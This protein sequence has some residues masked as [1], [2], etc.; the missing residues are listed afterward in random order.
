MPTNDLTNLFI[1][2]SFQRLL[3]ISP[4]DG[5]TLLDGT[6]SAA[7]IN[8]S[9]SLSGSFYGIAT[10]SFSGSFAGDGFYITNIPSSSLSNVLFTNKGDQTTQTV[11]GSVK[12]TQ[13]VIAENYIISSSVSYYTQSFYS[14]STNFGDSSGDTHKFTGSI[15]M[16]EAATINGGLVSG[17]SVAPK[18]TWGGG[19]SAGSILMEPG[20]ATGND[21]IKISNVPNGTPFTGVSLS[22]LLLGHTRNIYLV[23]T[24][25]S[26]SG[27]IHLSTRDA[28]TEGDSEIYI[29][30]NA[31]AGRSTA[32]TNMHSVFIGARNSHLTSGVVNSVMIATNARSGSA[33]DTLY[34]SN[35]NASGSVRFTGSLT[36]SSSITTGEI[37]AL[38]GDLKMDMTTANDQLLITSDAGAGGE[39]YF[40]LNATQAAFELYNNALGFGY[41]SLW[42]ADDIAPQ[43]SYTNLYYAD[44]STPD[45]AFKI[46]Q[47]RNSRTANVTTGEGDENP[48]L[49]LTT[50]ALSDFNYGGGSPSAANQKIVMAWGAD[51]LRVQEGSKYTFAIGS[52]DATNAVAVNP[53][54]NYVIG[55]PNADMRHNNVV[56]LGLPNF[57][58]T[59]ADTTYVKNLYVSSSVTGNSLQVNTTNTVFQNGVSGSF[60]GSFEGN[61]HSLT[62]NDTTQQFTGSF[63]GSIQGDGS[64]LTGTGI[65]G[66]SDTVPAAVLATLTDS[67][68]FQAGNG[69]DEGIKLQDGSG[70]LAAILRETTAGGNLRL[71]AADGSTSI[72]NLNNPTQGNYLK[73]AGINRNNPAG[74][75]DPF[76]V[77]GDAADKGF[78]LYDSGSRVNAQLRPGTNGGY[79]SLF[80][81]A[82]TTAVIQLN[83]PS[84]GSYINDGNNFGI[85]TA[86]P[87]TGKLHVV[88]VSSG[89]SAR[90]QNSTVEL[91]TELGAS[92]PVQYGIST[93]SGLGMGFQHAFDNDSKDVTTANQA[94]FHFAAYR[95]T[96]FAALNN[97]N[98]LAILRGSTAH[99]VIDT[100]G[101]IMHNKWTANQGQP[102]DGYDFVGSGDPTHGFL[103]RPV[104]ITSDG[105]D[106]DSPRFRL[107]G[108]YDSDDSAGVTSSDF[109]SV[110][111]TKMLSAGSSP[112]GYLSITMPSKTDAL[113][114][115]EDGNI[116]IGTTAPSASLEVNGNVI[117]TSFTGSFSGS[118][119]GD[120]TG[121]TGISSASLS[122]V[123]FTNL[124][125]SAVQLVD[126][127]LKLSGDI[128]AENY[129]VSSSVTYMTQS[130]SSGSTIFGDSA[131]DTHQFT[132]SLYVSGSTTLGSA[133][134][135][136]HKMTGSLDVSGA[137][138][139]FSKSFLIDHPLDPNK[140]LQYG[141]L[142]GPE[143]GVYV[144]GKLEEGNIITLPDYWNALVDFDSIT[145]QLTPI[146]IYQQLFV[147]AINNENGQIE[148]EVG[149]H[150]TPYCYYFVQGTRET[151]DVEF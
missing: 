78:R 150:D 2:Q 25:G 77:Q 123:V 51:G 126:G 48:S 105:T 59:A 52:P 115:R 103:L 41:R 129:I 92:R 58:T 137:F 143:H 141:S 29:K 125:D 144:R 8:M 13:D 81:A 10:G 40:Q 148:I 11:E 6:G 74:A 79:I 73:Y 28:Y 72:A 99:W 149:G 5:I 15:Y 107:R 98:L 147:S 37:N 44:P 131:D 108:T 87:S 12:F 42:I 16:Q 23:T 60:S 136:T 90:F 93:A 36:V 135:H 101:S 116:G 63:S 22:A 119:E 127:T 84:V 43:P 110:L 65:Y 97:A 20:N 56:V 31:S 3:Q 124:G 89:V 1:S 68:T 133:T 61:G 53:E 7:S 85:G 102:R 46:F 118:F 76:E 96:S 104:D 21:F 134:T 62:F 121:L 109:D 145:V 33:N 67:I 100:T 70:S 17:Q 24:E 122:N 30:N 69:N 114:I 49:V 38:T 106:L 138:K 71:V 26:T 142:E 34:T 146:G 57:T 9:G 88:G 91:R 94:S 18:I 19:D 39:G 128:I 47:D 86:S 14:G 80:D 50:T 151:I 113:S 27:S 83:H 112:Q 66:G 32:D 55:S 130:F 139:A 75:S 95:N 120:G 54:H 64:G 4:T 45:V 35:I 117:A 82:G 140:K 132:G 111:Q